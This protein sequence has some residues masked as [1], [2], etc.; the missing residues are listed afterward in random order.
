MDVL[1][2]GL[3]VRFDVKVITGHG[4]A[5]FERQSFTPCRSSP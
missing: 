3:K 5:K 4:L 1:D 2:Y